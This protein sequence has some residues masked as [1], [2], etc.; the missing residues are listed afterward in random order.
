MLLA[1]GFHEKLEAD[2]SNNILAAGS[3]YFVPSGRSSGIYHILT[4]QS[5]DDVANM[6]SLKGFHLMSVILS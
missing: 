6:L 2:D 5:F 3:F 1:T 4:Q